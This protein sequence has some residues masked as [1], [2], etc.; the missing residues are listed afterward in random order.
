M[1]PYI[2]VFEETQKLAPHSLP[3]LITNQ[4]GQRS[5]WMEMLTALS[6]LGQDWVIGLS[7]TCGNNEFLN[8]NSRITQT[9]PQEVLQEDLLFEGN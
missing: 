1:W 7:W 6:F 5:R 3:N 9:Y 8:L 4:V 2:G